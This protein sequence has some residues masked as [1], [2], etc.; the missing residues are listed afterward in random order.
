MPKTLL[1]QHL[2]MALEAGVEPFE[3]MH[4]HIKNQMVE[5]QD[6]AGDWSEGY[7]ECLTDLYRMCYDITFYLQDLKG[8]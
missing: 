4:G 3:V 7:N 1:P 6:V 2:A 5:L 8:N